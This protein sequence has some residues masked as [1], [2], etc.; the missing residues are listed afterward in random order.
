MRA[1]SFLRSGISG[2]PLPITSQLLF[3][4]KGVTAALG[5]LLLLLVVII[6]NLNDLNPAENAGFGYTRKMIHAKNHQNH[7]D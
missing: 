5:R 4:P 6:L 2:V 1:F 7:L 3:P